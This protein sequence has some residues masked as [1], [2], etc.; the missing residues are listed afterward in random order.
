MDI[1]KVMHFQSLLY[2]SEILCTELV[3]WYYNNLLARHSGIKMTRELVAHKYY[4]P[5]FCHGIE[6]YF[7]SCD[8]CLT[9]KT[10]KHKHYGDLQSLFIPSHCWKDLSIDFVMGLRIS[11]N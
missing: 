4:W 1:N 6:V 2:L 8:I 10:V 7:K 11:T 9:S 5:T 3:R